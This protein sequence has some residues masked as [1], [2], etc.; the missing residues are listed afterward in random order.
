MATP[1]EP[2]GLV[3]FEM[4][5]RK[6]VLVRDIEDR[7]QSLIEQC[8]ANHG[9]TLQE[10]I[11]HNDW[12]LQIE[13]DLSRARSRIE[14]DFRISNALSVKVREGK[15]KAQLQQR[16]DVLRAQCDVLNECIHGLSDHCAWFQDSGTYREAVEYLE[17]R[18]DD[19]EASPFDEVR[20]EIRCA[21]KSEGMEEPSHHELDGLI[22]S[23]SCVPSP[24]E[25]KRR[26]KKKNRKGGGQGAEELGAQ[27]ENSDDDEDGDGAREAEVGPPADFFA[28]DF[29]WLKA[30]GRENQEKGGYVDVWAPD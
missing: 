25:K 28:A 7:K 23:D 18:W 30:A 15:R 10:V 8:R 13:R 5:V 3:P 17:G 27:R 2:E 29:K 20:F 21:E 24:Q 4:I 19:D 9:L 16:L 6:G 1:A 22:H 11:D 12:L 14:R 26:K